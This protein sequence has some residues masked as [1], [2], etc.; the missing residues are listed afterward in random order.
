MN[1]EITETKTD[2]TTM[3]EMHLQILE[4][5]KMQLAGKERELRFIAANVDRLVEAM[6]E[7]AEESRVDYAN[8]DAYDLW[9]GNNIDFDLRATNHPNSVYHKVEREVAE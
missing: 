2:E 6:Y 8:C 7:R 5:Q 3:S 9:R 4:I 1:R